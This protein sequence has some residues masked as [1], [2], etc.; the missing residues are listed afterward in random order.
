MKNSIQ[1]INLTT[2]LPVTIKLWNGNFEL[3]THPELSVKIDASGISNTDLI[4]EIRCYNDQVYIGHQ[5]LTAVLVQS[6][7]IKIKIFVPDE[8]VVKLRQASGSLL[9]D[10]SYKKLETKNWCGDVHCHLDTIF[11]REQANLHIFSG[12]VYI[13][14]EDQSIIKSRAG[15]ENYQFFRFYNGSSVKAR[16]YIGDVKWKADTDNGGYYFA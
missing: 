11:V 14:T 10:G 13:D 4:P 8:S 6:E 1:H 3:H 7:A 16:T 15:Y 5:S 2:H 9:I 12:D